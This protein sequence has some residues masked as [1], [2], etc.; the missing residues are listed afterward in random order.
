MKLKQLYLYA[1]A[2]IKKIFPDLSGTYLVF[3][4]EKTDGFV[5]NPVSIHF[6]EQSDIFCIVRAKT[7]KICRAEKLCLDKKFSFQGLGSVSV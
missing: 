3:I 2:G 6:V 4:D 5:Y 7:F 1:S